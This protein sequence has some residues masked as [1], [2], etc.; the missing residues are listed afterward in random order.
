MMARTHP[1]SQADYMSPTRKV[2]ALIR[3]YRASDVWG[4]AF[5]FV[6]GAL[7]GSILVLSV[8]AMLD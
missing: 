1:G 2:Q 3:R 7:I 5:H 6:A 8:W 4:Q